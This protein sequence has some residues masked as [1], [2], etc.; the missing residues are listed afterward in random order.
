[1]SVW[2]DARELGRAAGEAAVLLAQG[3]ALG[4]IPNT[5]QFDSPGG[6]SMTSILLE[7]VPITRDNLNL[8]VDAEWITIDQLCQGVEAGAVE[9]CG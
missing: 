3:T 9:V 1:M 4:D 2:K 8:V 5:I 7:P 6:N